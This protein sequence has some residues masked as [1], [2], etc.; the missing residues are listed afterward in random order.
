MEPE[1]TT[2]DILF[3]RDYEVLDRGGEGG[4][5]GRNVKQTA[6]SEGMWVGSLSCEVNYVAPRYPAFNQLPLFLLRLLQFPLTERR[7]ALFS[8]SSHPENL[9]EFHFC[10]MY[11]LLRDSTFIIN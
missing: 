3:W 1:G 4:G 6:D 2:Q 11:A 10:R 8:S 9:M 5:W 7:A